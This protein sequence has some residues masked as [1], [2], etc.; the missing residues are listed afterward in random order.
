M[1]D[2]YLQ[3]AN[4]TSLQILQS[5]IICTGSEVYGANK[6]H[7]RP[8]EHWWRISSVKNRRTLHF[9]VYRGKWPKLHQNF[10]ECGQTLFFSISI[11]ISFVSISGATIPMGGSKGHAPKMPKVALCFGIMHQ[12]THLSTQN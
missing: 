7:F 4:I 1:S 2:M 8:S 9:K 10:S 5:K 6:K 3:R 12:N 11:S